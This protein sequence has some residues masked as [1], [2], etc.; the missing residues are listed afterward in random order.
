[1]IFDNRQITNREISNDADISFCSGQIFLWIFQVM[2]VRQQIFFQNWLKSCQ[3]R[4]APKRSQLVTN[5]RCI[6]MT[7]KIKLFHQKGSIPNAKKKSTISSV[8]CKSFAHCFFLFC[9]IAM[10]ATR[11]LCQATCQKHTELQKNKTCILH[12][13]ALKQT[14]TTVFTGL[15]HRRHFPIPKTEDTFLLRLRK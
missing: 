6:A 11:L 12:D 5:H 15:G 4:F 13:K 10:M 14:P 9:I 2:K 3:T 8:K 7:S 1:M